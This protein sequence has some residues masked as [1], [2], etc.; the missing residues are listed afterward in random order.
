MS[1]VAV[2]LVVANVVLAIVTL[3]HFL[4]IRRQVEKSEK[5][6]ADFKLATLRQNRYQMESDVTQLRITRAE[7]ADNRAAAREILDYRENQCKKT[8]DRIVGLM[9]ELEKELKN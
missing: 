8:I 7:L 9:E 6:F 1:Y 4:T 5:D 3:L 2:A